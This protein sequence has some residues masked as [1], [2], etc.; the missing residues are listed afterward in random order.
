MSHQNLEKK[1]NTHSATLNNFLNKKKNSKM[2]VVIIKFSWRWSHTRSPGGPC[3]H[4]KID[5]PT[6][7][8]QTNLSTRF[9]WFCWNCLSGKVGTRQKYIKILD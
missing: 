5:T 3:L 2:S 6:N 8:F 4:E 1:Y 9:N 7:K